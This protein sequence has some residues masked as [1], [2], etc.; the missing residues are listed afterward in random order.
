M[1]ENYKCEYVTVEIWRLLLSSFNLSAAS[2]GYVSTA[3]KLEKY[4]HGA[5]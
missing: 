2:S 4:G 5:L 1:K 3:S